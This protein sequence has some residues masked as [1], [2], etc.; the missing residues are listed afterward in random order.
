MTLKNIMVL[1]RRPWWYFGLGAGRASASRMSYVCEKMSVAEKK[2]EM[3]E[4]KNVALKKV[5]AKGD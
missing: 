1:E 4:K 2:I 3:L 5:L